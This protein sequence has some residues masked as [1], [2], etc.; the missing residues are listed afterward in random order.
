M[1]IVSLRSSS[2]G[3]HDGCP[4]SYMLQYLLNYKTPSGKAAAMG[5]VLHKA[6]ELLA[7]QKLCEQEGRKVFEDDGLGEIDATILTPR[8]AVDMAYGYYSRVEDHISFSAADLRQCHKWM[9]MTLS[10]ENGLYDPRKR[11]IVAPEQKFNIVIKEDWARYD[12]TLQDGQKIEGYLELQGTMDL[13]T[14]IDEETY[15]CVDWKFGAKATDWNAK[16]LPANGSFP[17]KDYKKFL[18]DPQLLIYFYAARTI[19]PKIPNIIFTINY[20]RDIGPTTLAFDDADYL[21]AEKI[22]KEKFLEIKRDRRPELRKGKRCDFCW[23]AKN[24]YKET[25]LTYCDFFDKAVSKHGV[26]GVFEKYGQR[27]KLGEY[28]DGGGRRAKE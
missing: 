9:E 22:I 11:T 3:Q 2:Y 5:N 14:K 23:F 20:V 26:D 4:Q 21:Y 27:D 17:Q 25:G 28:Q 10:Y 12:Y 7:H 13:I 18:K 19:F 24:Q 6:L 16:T 1:I 8:L 15:E